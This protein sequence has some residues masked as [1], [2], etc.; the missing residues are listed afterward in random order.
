MTSWEGDADSEANDKQT[1][2]N[3]SAGERG[4]YEEKV[5]MIPIS[6]TE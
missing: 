6:N 4:E 2:K 3:M 1:D 5:K